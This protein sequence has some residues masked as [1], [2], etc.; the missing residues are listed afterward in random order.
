MKNVLGILITFCL[1]LLAGCKSSSTTSESE[2]QWLANQMDSK[3]LKAEFDFVLPMTTNSLVQLGN[4]GM[5]PAGSNAGRISLLGNQGRFTMK[6]DS[7]IADLPYFGERQ[8]GGSYNPKDVGINFKGVADDLVIEKN[9]K[10]NGYEI[11]FDIGST[12]SSEQ[13]RVNLFIFP[14]K[15]ARMSVNSNQRFRVGYEGSLVSGM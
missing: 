15:T 13:F 5:F 1:L 8:L 4:A 9:K 2:R 12:T 11:Q 10:N 14:N 3:E 6:G 7:V